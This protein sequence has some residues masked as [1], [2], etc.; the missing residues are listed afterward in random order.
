MRL[1]FILPFVAASLAMAIQ[2][3]TRC[4][5]FLTAC[6]IG[7]G[8]VECVDVQSNLETCGGCSPDVSIFACLSQGLRRPLGINSR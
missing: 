5:D 3:A 1:A 2:P 6:P 7:H 4:P 8:I